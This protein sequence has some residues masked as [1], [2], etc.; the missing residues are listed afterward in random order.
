MRFALT[1]EQR[2]LKEGFREF[3]EAA[4]PIEEGCVSSVEQRHEPALWSGRR[5]ASSG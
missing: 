3:L 4:Y 1:E 2:E 5:L